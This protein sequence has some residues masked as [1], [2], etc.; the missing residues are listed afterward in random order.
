MW[1]L[2]FFLYSFLLLDFGLWWVFFLLCLDCF[3]WSSFWAFSFL[4][5]CF[6][7]WN[8]WTLFW[9]NSFCKDCS[10]YYCWPCLALCFTCGG[11][12]AARVVEEHSLLLELVE[13]LMPFC[14]SV[15]WGVSKLVLAGSE[16]DGSLSSSSRRWFGAMLVVSLIATFFFFSSLGLGAGGSC[17]LVLSVSSSS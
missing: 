5:T 1:G 9:L 8:G 17:S 11:V 15:V 3:S 6:C 2:I 16:T 4:V 13:L 7:F 12:P 14:S 10:Y